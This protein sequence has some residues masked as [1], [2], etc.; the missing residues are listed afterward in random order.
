MVAEASRR[1]SGRASPGTECSSS[2]S[3]TS[4]KLR[5]RRTRGATAATS[6][7]ARNRLELSSHEGPATASSFNKATTSPR[8]AATPAFTPRGEA[9]VLVQAD[10]A[11]VRVCARSADADRVLRAV[12]DE[13]DL[14]DLITDRLEAPRQPFGRTERDDDGRGAQVVAFSVERS[15]T[16][17]MKP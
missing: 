5:A 3:T 1:P 17:S 2:S 13:D 10:H 11:D 4:A 9:F 6:P 12:V 15:M 16:R 8:A 14:V 7:A